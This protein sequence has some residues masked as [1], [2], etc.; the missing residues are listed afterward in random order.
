[1]ATTCACG[2]A[3][4]VDHAMSCSH[5]GIIIS[6]HNEIRDLTATLLSEVI[7]CVECEPVL[8]TLS[9]EVLNGRSA[10][11]QD[12]YGIMHKTHF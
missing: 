7:E 10:N 4:D 5:G 8:Q 9:G 6:R 12:E 1:M 3:N 11:I 2:E